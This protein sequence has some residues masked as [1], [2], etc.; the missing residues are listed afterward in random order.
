MHDTVQCSPFTAPL[1]LTA[2]Q[3]EMTGWYFV[4]ILMISVIPSVVFGSASVRS[5][6]QYLDFSFIFWPY[7]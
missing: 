3:V 4:Y 2:P 6:T 1:A 5:V 7:S